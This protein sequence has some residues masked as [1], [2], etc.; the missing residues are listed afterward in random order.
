MKETK[1]TTA[2]LIVARETGKIRKYPP[3]IPPNRQHVAKM[4]VDKAIIDHL[5]QFIQK[6]MEQNRF[7]GE[8]ITFEHE[9]TIKEIRQIIENLRENWETKW[10]NERK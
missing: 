5:S 1:Q 7:E 9:S 4:I 2:Q 8:I 6:A 10:Q 3:P